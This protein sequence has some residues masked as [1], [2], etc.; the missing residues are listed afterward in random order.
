[1]LLMPPLTLAPRQMLLDPPRRLDEIHRIIV[2]L[3]D[4]GRHRQDVRIENNIGRLKPTC[5]V[6]ILYD[7]AQ[8]SF[9]RS[10]LSA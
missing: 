10:R 8:I 6:R 2:V 3:L 1:M 4:P 5:S 9:L 7:L